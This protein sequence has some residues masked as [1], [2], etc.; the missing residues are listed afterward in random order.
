MDTGCACCGWW[1]GVAGGSLAV[2]ERLAGIALYMAVGNAAGEN[3]ILRLQA[4]EAALAD[5]NRRLVDANR[6]LNAEKNRIKPVPASDRKSTG[7]RG[8]PRGTAPT[9]NRRPRDIDRREVANMERCPKG[10]PLSG[11]TATYT[12]AVRETR[13]I[14]E[15]VKHTVCRRWCRTCRK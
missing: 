13:V 10:H 15:N 11:I 2:A 9:I 7:V 6:S 14:R 12:G 1:G 4:A 5:D 3:T 8:R